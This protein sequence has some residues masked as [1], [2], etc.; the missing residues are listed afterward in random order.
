MCVLCFILCISCE[1]CFSLVNVSVCVCVCVCCVVSCIFCVQRLSS[2]G[3]V[4]FV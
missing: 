3:L 2:L 1:Q 4:G